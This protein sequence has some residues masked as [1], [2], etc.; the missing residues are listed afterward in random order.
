MGRRRRRITSRVGRRMGRRGARAMGGMG[1]AMA[2]GRR[3]GMGARRRRL[4]RRRLVLGMEDLAMVA[5]AMAV[6]DSLRDMD[7]ERLG[8]RASKTS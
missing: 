2:V 8:V 3:E 5:L 4:A 6:M 7:I 1:S